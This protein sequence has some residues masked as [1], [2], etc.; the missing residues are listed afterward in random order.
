[1]STCSTPCRTSACTDIRRLSAANLSWSINFS[2]SLT[3]NNFNGC[4]S[5]VGFRFTSQYHNNNTLTC[6]HIYTLCPRS[7]HLMSAV[8][9]QT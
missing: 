6:K 3:L 1:L 5:A 9:E 8:R 2:G 4:F 7:R